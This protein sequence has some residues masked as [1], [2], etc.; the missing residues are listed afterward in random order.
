M[1]RRCGERRPLKIVIPAQAGTQSILLFNRH[2]PLNGF[3]SILFFERLVAIKISRQSTGFS[4][5]TGE[6]E[7]RGFSIA[8]SFIARERKTVVAPSLT[9]E[10]Y[11]ATGLISALFV[12]VAPS[13]TPEG[14][15]R[16]AGN[17]HGC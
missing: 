13:L 8:G 14:Y 3:A 17:P 15:N 2:E 4:L 11:N 16:L 12:V 1:R 6:R 5:L 7:A 10:D 9:P